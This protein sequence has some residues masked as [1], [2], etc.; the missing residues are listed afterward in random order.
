M[1]FILFGST[2]EMG[3]KSRELFK[4]RG[5]ELIQKFNYVPD[6]TILQE[7]FGRRRRYSRECV[8][9]CDFVYESNGMLV[10]FNKDQIIDAVRGRKKCILTMSAHTIDFVKQI[11]A[12]YGEYV[13]VIGTYID[14]KTLQHLFES[15][16]DVP[17]AEI[18][19][20]TEI[21]KQIKRCLLE[22][23]EVFD[24]IAIY[25]GE[26]SEFNFDALVVQYE[27]MIERAERREKELNNKM[28]VEMPYTGQEDY[29]FVSYAHTD[30]EQVFPI[31]R[32]LQLA[33]YRIWYDEG[34]NG[35]EN[36]RKILASKIQSENCRNFL[37]FA[38][39][40]STKSRNV[41]AEVNAALNFEKKIVTVRLDRSSFTMD[42]E[43]YLQTYQTLSAQDAEFCDKLLRSIEPSVQ[44]GGLSFGDQ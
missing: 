11:K 10:G 35:G 13:T 22:E 19:C 29:L 2:S 27:F 6:N 25:G 7:R 12:A 40:N 16:P 24:H 30:T 38:S 20:R 43:M 3:K 17:E 39:A 5:F 9:Q 33:G 15:L 1:L 31:L 44:A 32:K 36:W 14:E 41:Q 8:L 18:A 34:I 23:R 4:N 21:G 26:D 28:Y 37:L 42:L